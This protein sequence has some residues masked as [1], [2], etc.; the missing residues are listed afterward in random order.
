MKG[1]TV[2]QSQLKEI[3][4][5]LEI[6][7]FELAT[8][9]SNVSKRSYQISIIAFNSSDCTVDGILYG[10]FNNKN[11][12]F[13]YANTD[14]TK[15]MDNARTESD[16]AKQNALYKQAIQQISND[17]VVVPWFEVS[18]NYIFAKNL[19]G[20]TINNYGVGGLNRYNTVYW[21]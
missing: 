17:A 14:V 20:F 21:K 9:A 12:S 1:I 19:E 3:G 16:A 13:G 11:G 4:I 2:I 15:W 5:D 6:Q 10:K 8:W 18:L 7:T